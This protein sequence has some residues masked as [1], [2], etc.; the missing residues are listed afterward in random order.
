MSS[1]QRHLRNSMT[2][3]AGT[4]VTVFS[5]RECQWSDEQSGPRN[6]PL[7]HDGEI[8]DHRRTATAEPLQFFGT[9]Q[10]QS[11]V[12]DN[13]GHVVSVSE[14]C[15]PPGKLHDLHNRDVDHCNQQQGKHCGPTNCRTTRIGLCTTTGNVHDLV[16]ERQLRKL[17]S[18]LCC[19]D[20][21]T[22]E[23][24]GHTKPV[25]SRL[26]PVASVAEV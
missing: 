22:W 12:V 5:N 7:R 14:N 26:T 20:K 8:D 16:E 23:N 9:V 21:S 13:N 19:L 2:S 10:L 4:S 15:K 3:T 1:P 25:T 18:Y 11:P 6:L 17:H 24:C